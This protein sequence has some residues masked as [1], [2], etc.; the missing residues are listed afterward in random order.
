M[1]VIRLLESQVVGED[2]Q[3]IRA[4]ISDVVRQELNAVSAHQSEKGVVSLFKVGLP[5][6]DF[7]GGELAL[8]DTD[9]EVA[10][11]AC[12]LQ[13]PRVDTLGLALDEI[14]HR[15]NHPCGGKDFPMIG[16]TLL[17]PGKVHGTTP[18]NVSAL[19]NGCSCQRL[20]KSSIENN[21]GR[22]DDD[23]LPTKIAFRARGVE[24]A[25]AYSS[26]M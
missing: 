12:R 18:F 11:S 15:L 6:L 7:D 24:M 2:L 3:H 20:E 26:P 21:M 10:A 14:E 13:E 22:A 16:D 4:A 1:E 25:W 5:E 19:T 9:E 23:A 17:R 8:Q